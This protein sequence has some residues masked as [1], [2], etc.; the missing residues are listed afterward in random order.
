MR[1]KTLQF[2]DTGAQGTFYELN[3][4]DSQPAGLQT[5]D[6]ENG[7]ARKPASEY[8]SVDMIIQGNEPARGTRDNDSW[9]DEKNEPTVIIHGV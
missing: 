2:K 8:G 5:M 7:R 6:E 3:N 1:L 9:Q 4:Y